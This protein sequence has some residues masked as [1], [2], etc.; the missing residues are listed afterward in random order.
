[1][2]VATGYLNSTVA[3]T[4]YTMQSQAATPTF[5]E[6]TGTYTGTQ[7]ITLS[8][9]TSGATIYYA[10]NGTPTTS[11]TK[12]RGNGDFGE[13]ERDNRSDGGWRRIHAEHRGER[14]V[15]NQF[16]SGATD[17]QR[18]DGN[19]HRDA[20][21]QVERH[22]SWSDNLLCDQQHAHDVVDQVHGDGDFSELERDNPKRWRLPVDTRRALLQARLIRSTA[23]QTS[24]IPYVQGTYANPGSAQTGERRLY[25]WRR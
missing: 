11:S 1:M 22:D 18:G 6:G 3:S 16:A 21:D 2:A 9:T 10:I 24:T 8:D 5:S 12:S 4:S 13:L 17:V 19:V 20:V 23:V 15:H 7:S 14:D 25:D